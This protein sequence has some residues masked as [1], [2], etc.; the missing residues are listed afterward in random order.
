MNAKITKHTQVAPGSALYEDEN[1]KRLTPKEWDIAEPNVE[2]RGRRNPDS[3][4]AQLASEHKASRRETFPGYYEDLI[5][6]GEVQRETKNNFI[7]TRNR[8]RPKTEYTK[9]PDGSLIKKGYI[10]LNN[11]LLENSI[12]LQYGD[13]EQN[14]P[15][16]AN[17]YERRQVGR[18]VGDS[19]RE[20]GEL[21]KAFDTF[22]EQNRE[23]HWKRDVAEIIG[24]TYRDK[25]FQALLRRRVQDGTIR[26]SR[27]GDK[28]RWVNKDWKRNRL[29]K[30]SKEKAYLPLALPFG[31]EKYI[32]TTKHSEIILAG[33]IGSGKTHWGYELANL[34]VGKIPIRH[35][36]NEMGDAKAELLLEDFPKLEQSLEDGYELINLDKEALYVA[37]NIDPDG[38]NIYDYLHL[39]ANKEWFLWLG[40]ELAT[41]SQKLNEGVVVVML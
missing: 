31:A 24:T 10:P 13:R 3:N 33:D 41:L 9:Q 38:L 23:E 35:F 14:Q 28:I 20:Y 6:A 19:P 11:P 29:V 16:N 1:G 27:G 4:K 2:F 39:P 18:Q 26:V 7:L 21:S 32:A 36:F 34:N 25:S 15:K 30:G 17:T 37:E 5:P 12:S 40:K 22:L 8:Y